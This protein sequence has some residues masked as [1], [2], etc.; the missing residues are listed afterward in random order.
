MLGPV[1]T[2]PGIVLDVAADDGPAALARV[3]ADVRLSDLLVEADAVEPS[4]AL[5]GLAVR[6]PEPGGLD[7][8][9]EARLRPEPWAESTEGSAAK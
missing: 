7:Q 1:L 2:C 4:G 6:P 8:P 5:V 3:G 9:N